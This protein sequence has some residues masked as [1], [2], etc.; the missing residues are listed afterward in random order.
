MSKAYKAI[1][2]LPASADHYNLTF[3]LPEGE[4]FSYYIDSPLK[5]DS[6]FESYLIRDVIPKI[7]ASSQSRH[8][9]IAT[10]TRTRYKHKSRIHRNHGPH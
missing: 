6:Q 4:V 10:S 9:R 5:K 7:D 2:I 8:A 3:V 1:V